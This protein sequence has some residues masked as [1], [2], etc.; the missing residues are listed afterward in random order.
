[1]SSEAT[2]DSSVLIPAKGQAKNHTLL[3]IAFGV[4]YVVWGSTYL[5]IR[6][7]IE[8]F[9]PLLLAGT[10]HLSVG[11]LLYPILRWK[12]GIRPT[13]AHWKTA[14]ISGCLLL[15]SNGGVCLSEETLPT[16]IAAL[17]VATVSLWMVV[18]DWLRPGGLRPVPRVVA[19]LIFGFAGLALMVGPA[20]LGGSSRIDIKGAA[21]LL[22]ASLF[23]ASGSVYAKHGTMPSSPML[24]VSMQALSGGSLLWILSLIT[25]ELRGFHFAAVTH[26]SWLAVGYLSVFGSMLGFTA[27]L[28]MLR[29]SS[30]TRV[31]TYAFVN[32]VVALFLGWLFIG[33]AITLR[34]LLAG[35]VILTAV[36]LVISAPQRKPELQQGLGAGTEA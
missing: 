23:W 24:G 9:P 6:V 20:H 25:G 3:L 13:A 26:A 30:A 18:V 29:E 10:R 35:L 14:G 31:S 36:L 12:T 27:Y 28:Y 19:G 2:R 21:I 7:G 5:A 4:V 8:S 33:E 1:M 17:L 22:I 32:P 34:T 16:G 15:L 11:L